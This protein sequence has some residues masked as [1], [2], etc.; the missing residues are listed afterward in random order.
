MTPMWGCVI[1]YAI[2]NMYLIKRPTGLITP[3]EEQTSETPSADQFFLKATVNP[4]P[5]P[6]GQTDGTVRQVR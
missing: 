5:P 3:W 2:P 6:P 1:F 4:N